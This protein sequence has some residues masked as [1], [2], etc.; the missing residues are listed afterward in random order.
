MRLWGMSGL[1][2]EVAAS[3]APPDFRLG[4][5]RRWRQTPPWIP[6]YVLKGPHNALRMEET[7]HETTDALAY[8]T[9]EQCLAVSRAFAAVAF[10]ISAGNERA[11]LMKL[12]EQHG[13]LVPGLRLDI[14]C[15][16]VYP[17]ILDPDA[18]EC[19]EPQVRVLP[20]LVK[21]VP[22]SKLDSG[23]YKSQV[24]LHVLKS[25]PHLGLAQVQV[26]DEYD[27]RSLI[28]DAFEREL[29]SLLTGEEIE[30]MAFRVV[31]NGNP[32]IPAGSQD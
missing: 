16:A 29:D 6:A 22:T 19:L 17:G 21:G 9:R 27:A 5:E 32:Y 3:H 18:P 14:R 2:F 15:L 30:T 26:L 12:C 25:N 7:S 10:Q 28:N 20:V 1:P 8:G 23:I 24:R 11:T 4:R 13:L 31:K